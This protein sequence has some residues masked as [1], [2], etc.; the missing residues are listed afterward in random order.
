MWISL[1]RSLLGERGLKSFT[2]DK[3]AGFQMSLSAWRAWI[4]IKLEELHIP[5]CVRSLS[6]WR[7]WIE[8]YNYFLIKCLLLSSLS[9]WRA[10]IEIY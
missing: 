1:C 4:E 5:V 9:A 8:I 3:I 7:A 2:S 10:W 6:A